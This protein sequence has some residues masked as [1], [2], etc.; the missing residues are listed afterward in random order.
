MMKTNLQISFPPST[1]LQGTENIQLPFI[2]LQS[3]DNIW[4]FL[5]PFFEKHTESSDEGELLG[6][7]Q[8]V[9]ETKENYYQNQLML[10]IE[11]YYGTV[12][13][14]VKTNFKFM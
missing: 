6:I 9:S 10:D 3:T 11:K 2:S 7:T 12:K 4:G 1:P 5:Q 13:W 8:N 14:I